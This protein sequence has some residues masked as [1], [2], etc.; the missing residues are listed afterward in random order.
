M[1][2]SQALQQQFPA[3]YDSSASTATH[4]VPVS[5]GCNRPDSQWSCPHGTKTHPSRQMLRLF[6]SSPSVG[7]CT[8][9][10]VMNAYQDKVYFMDPEAGNLAGQRPSS[11]GTLVPQ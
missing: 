10:C 5:I 8:L 1:L 7:H 11:F 9:D 4:V 6:T 2:A 3:R